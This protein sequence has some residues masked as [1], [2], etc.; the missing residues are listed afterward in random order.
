M[1]LKS[2]TEGFFRD[3][4]KD[5]LDKISNNLTNSIKNSELY[6]EL[7]EKNIYL[8][9][10]LEMLQSIDKLITVVYKEQD[11]VTAI[12]YILL[13]LVNKI[14]LGYKEAYFFQHDE[15]TKVLSCT[16]YY[17]NLKN[18]TEEK[19]NRVTAKEIWSNRIRIKEEKNNI[20]TRAFKN[21]EKQKISLKFY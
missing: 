18:Y 4:P 7:E 8:N 12:Y 9:S 11:K 10:L 1:I 3:L 13:I 5:I 2:K 20:L 19:E 17:Y 6:N 16:N 21:N 14:K 15:D